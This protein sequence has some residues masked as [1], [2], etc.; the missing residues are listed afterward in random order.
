VAGSSRLSIEP[1]RG[2]TTD[3]FQAPAADSSLTKWTT[4]AAIA[5]RVERRRGLA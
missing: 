5:A 2:S 1:T 4:G 3:P